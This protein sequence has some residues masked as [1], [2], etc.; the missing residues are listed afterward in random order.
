[1]VIPIFHNGVSLSTTGS[2]LFFNLTQFNFKL[3]AADIS[4]TPLV[5]TVLYIDQTLLDDGPTFETVLY[6]PRFNDLDFFFFQPATSRT[7]RLTINNSRSTAS[8]FQSQQFNVTDDFM[9]CTY[10]ETKTFVV[11]PV[12]VYAVSF[13]GEFSYYL[14]SRQ[15]NT[16]QS[17]SLSGHGQIDSGKYT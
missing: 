9:R 7:L 14:N 1:M 15:A 17:T 2:G 3:A 13:T 4:D 16:F 11:V 6:G 5:S 12:Q 8:L 10:D